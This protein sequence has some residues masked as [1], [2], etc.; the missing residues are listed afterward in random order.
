MTPEKQQ[1]FY[2][3]MEIVEEGT[4]LGEEAEEIMEVFFPGDYNRAKSY[5]CFQAFTSSNQYDT[6][7]DRIVRDI[8][9]DEQENDR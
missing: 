8:E 4:A 6:T 5:G 2:R 9:K 3:L 1:K 7:L